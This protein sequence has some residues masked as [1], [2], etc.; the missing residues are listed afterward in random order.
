MKFYSFGSYHH[1]IC[2]V[3]NPK[4]TIDH[5][6][7]NHFTLKLAKGV[8][9]NV[10]KKRLDTLREPYFEGGILSVHKNEQEKVI[11]FKDPNGH[12]IEVIE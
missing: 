6:H 4:V 7:W 8:K 1:D 10:I 9:L 5:E 11:H 3:Y 12:V 2:L